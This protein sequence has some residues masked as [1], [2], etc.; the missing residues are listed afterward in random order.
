MIDNQP[1]AIT[2]AEADRLFATPGR[3]KR[4]A[5]WL[6]DKNIRRIALPGLPGSAPAMLFA[7]LPKRRIPYL[8]I[9]ADAEE[10][11]YLYNDLVQISGD[12]AAVAIFPSGYKRHIKYGQPDPPARILRTETLDAIRNSKELRWVVTSPDALEEKE[13]LPAELAT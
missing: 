7:A 4:I 11:G 6:D 1:A 12:A 13:P 8:V 3:I 9:A 10:A 5:E 2:L